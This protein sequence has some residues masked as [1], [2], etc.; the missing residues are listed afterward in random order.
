MSKL[1]LESKSD[2]E[3]VAILRTEL[4]NGNITGIDQSN[5][6]SIL[7]Y[8]GMNQSNDNLISKQHRRYIIDTLCYL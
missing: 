1:D 4:Y 6:K 7:I 8:A 3:L 5:S 2:I